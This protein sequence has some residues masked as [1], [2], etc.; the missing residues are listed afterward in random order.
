MGEIRCK[1]CGSQDIGK[2][3]EL[4]EAKQKNKSSKEYKKIIY[5]IRK[6]GFETTKNL[7]LHFKHKKNEAAKNQRYTEAA[8]FGE[9][10]KQLF[11]ELKKLSNIIK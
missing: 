5:E 3:H 9:K 8:K 1:Y 11:K 10:E 4:I 6:E 2:H 7:V